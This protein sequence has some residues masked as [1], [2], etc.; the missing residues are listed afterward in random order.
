L[1]WTIQ[2]TNG[3]PRLV[4]TNPGPFHVS[5]VRIELRADGQSVVLK[6]TPMAAPM[7]TQSFEFEGLKPV[8]GIQVNF[9]VITDY[10]GYTTPMTL[11]VGLDS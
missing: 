4:V 8:P 2:N 11:T 5:F 3:K 6:D 1:R 7:D 10:G 9:S